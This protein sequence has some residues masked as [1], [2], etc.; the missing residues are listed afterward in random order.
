MRFKSG[1]K[2]DKWISAVWM[3]RPRW[4]D[5]NNFSLRV[6]WAASKL[7]SKT[8]D[9]VFCFWAPPF[10]FKI[11]SKN[12]LFSKN[13]P[14]VFF[15][16]NF[17]LYHC[18]K[19]WC[20]F[21][22]KYHIF[23]LRGMCCTSISSC[24]IP[25]DTATLSLPPIDFE[26]G[27]AVWNWE[28]DWCYP[29][30]WGNPRVKWPNVTV[31]E[32]SAFRYYHSWQTKCHKTGLVSSQ[33]EGWHC[34]SIHTQLPNLQLAVQLMLIKISERKNKVSLWKRIDNSWLN[35]ASVGR[36]MAKEKRL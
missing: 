1:G 34:I 14:P 6:L 3:I 21:Q 11:P 8:C 12:L 15:F 9:S 20:L 7:M 25:W 22:A 4:R 36:K 23:L 35:Q 16:F 13:N 27:T 32:N 18:M 28:D 24:Q 31:C 17:E 30:S 26:M 5:S 10:S 2:S 29:E 19:K 33:G